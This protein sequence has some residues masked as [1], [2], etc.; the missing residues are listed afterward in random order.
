M[1][2]TLFTVYMLKKL[3]RKLII[4][5]YRK[6]VF[7]LF[8]HVQSNL[9]KTIVIST[10]SYCRTDPERIRATD[11]R[12]SGIESLN[13]PCI[14]RRADSSRYLQYGSCETAGPHGGFKAS[15]PALALFWFLLCPE[16]EFSDLKMTWS[17]P[18]IESLKSCFEEDT[19]RSN[20]DWENLGFHEN[21]QSG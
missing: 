18:S 10:K 13:Q 6:K 1:L 9:F 21:P 11:I 14:A 2:G 4:F 7:C 8:I 16:L 12:S 15:A 20:P 17:L 19:F 3:F 5:L